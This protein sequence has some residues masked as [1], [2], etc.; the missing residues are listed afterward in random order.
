MPLAIAIKKL[1]IQRT[2]C[3]ALSG[4]NATKKMRNATKAQV[5]TFLATAV[6]PPDRC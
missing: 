4:R 5:P 1:P 3:A 2:A 6:H